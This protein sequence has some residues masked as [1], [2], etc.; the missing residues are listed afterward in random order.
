MKVKPYLITNN[1]DAY[2]YCESKIECVFVEGTYLDVLEKTRDYIHT[3]HKLLS[4][5]M[6]GSVKPNQTPYRSII[7]DSLPAE[8]D[9]VIHSTMMIE[10]GIDSAKKFLAGKAAMK[11]ND[12]IK[13]DFR[14]V[15]LSFISRY[16]DSVPA[17]GNL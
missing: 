12:K 7:L 14:T 17:S 1:I 9:E 6:A 16:V 5:P 10:N 2:N 15:D 8:R 4:H 11:W 3:G 13:K